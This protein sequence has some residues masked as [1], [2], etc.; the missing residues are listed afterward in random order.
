MA[1]EPSELSVVPEWVPVTA[2]GI[3]RML[4]NPIAFYMKDAKRIA[5][6]WCDT[7]AAGLGGPSPRREIILSARAVLRAKT[8]ADMLPLMV[9]L[10]N[11]IRLECR[12]MDAEEA[13][14]ELRQLR[15][16]VARGKQAA[17][18]LA[19]MGRD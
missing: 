13:E 18:K 11:L 8:F 19:I 10:C 15:C 7:D 4:K 12:A 5:T 16:M 2:A 17:R 14:E 9:D 1:K 3:K 6:T